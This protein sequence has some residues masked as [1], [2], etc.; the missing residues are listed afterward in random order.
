[1][2][3]SNVLTHI[4]DPDN[5]RSDMRKSALTKLVQKYL[6][7]TAD[8]KDEHV[9]TTLFNLIDGNHRTNPFNFEK[10]WQIIRKAHNANSHS[11][12]IPVQQ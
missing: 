1:M 11:Q 9:I 12:R 4:F 8:P 5:S 6:G 10:E 3:T 2:G 7:T